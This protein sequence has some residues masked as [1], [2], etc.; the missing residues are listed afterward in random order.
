MTARSNAMIVL[1]CLLVCGGAS[2][3]SAMAVYS[4][5]FESVEGY[6]LGDLDGQ[7]GWTADA[8]PGDSAVQAADSSSGL[9]SLQI[10]S[11]GGYVARNV[12]H[13]GAK[14]SF[15]IPTNT[16][17]LVTISQD[18]K[19]TAMQEA[20]YH[21]WVLSDTA[22]VTCSAGFAPSGDII[23]KG[24][25]T[26]Y[27][28]IPNQWRTLSFVLDYDL[29]I[30]DVF[31]GG[32]LIADNVPFVTAGPGFGG[33]SILTDDYTDLGSS[34]F[35]DDLDIIAIPEPATVGLLALGGLALLCRRKK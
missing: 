27:D 2:S 26:G 11:D 6:F 3:V 17:P 7:Q 21:V 20:G 9:W 16:H 1:F 14:R 15:A 31:Y 23:V 29:R 35:Y 10:T 25:D 22:I 19:I 24:I 4:P 30:G 32:D 33:I 34:M 5:S 18:V 12:L 8:A 28:W 13:Y